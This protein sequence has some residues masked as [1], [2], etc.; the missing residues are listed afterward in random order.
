MI[1]VVATSGV[2]GCGQTCLADDCIYCICH[3]HCIKMMGGC[4]SKKH[5]LAAAMAVACVPPS[6]TPTIA[7][8]PSLL[9]PIIVRQ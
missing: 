6:L 5:K 8:T 3:K 9:G 4:S 1:K 7:Y 2:P